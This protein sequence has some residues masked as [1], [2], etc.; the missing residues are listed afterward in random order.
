MGQVREHHR[1]DNCND[2][3]NIKNEEK[4]EMCDPWSVSPRP[5]NCHVIILEARSPK[6]LASAD[7]TLRRNDSGK[8]SRLLGQPKLVL[9]SR[10]QYFHYMASASMP[11]SRLSNGP[12][13]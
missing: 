7:N 4:L 12:C 8:M 6:R 5:L 11:E 3:E 2:S 1:N 13:L 9:A 10:V